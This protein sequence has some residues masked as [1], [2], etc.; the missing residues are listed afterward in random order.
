MDLTSFGAALSGLKTISDLLKSASDVNLATRINA[1]V[2]GIQGQ[3]INVQQQALSLQNE[4]QEL[5]EKL[6]AIET[7][8]SFRQELT[9]KNNVYIKNPSRPDQEIYCSA[10]LDLDKKRVRIGIE[11]GS[12]ACPK[13]GYMEIVH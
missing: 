3:L 10:C 2:I 9:F 7:D 12:Y 1:E 8:Q 11:G 5:R 13:H 4:N 6:R